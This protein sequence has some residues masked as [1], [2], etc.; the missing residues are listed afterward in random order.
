MTFTAAFL[1]FGPDVPKLAEVLRIRDEDADRLKNWMMDNKPLDT[2]Q[3]KSI[4]A[5][6]RRM[7][8]RNA[9]RAIRNG[10]GVAA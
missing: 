7:V 10:S 8:A 2:L 9:L 3:V 4:N 1:K 6:C 5:K